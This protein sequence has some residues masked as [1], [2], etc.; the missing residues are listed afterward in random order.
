MRDRW[1]EKWRKERYPRSNVFH[2]IDRIEK[3]MEEMIDEMMR[4]AFSSFEA[5]MKNKRIK[6]PVYVFSITRSPEGRPRIREFDNI[7][8]GRYDPRIM[9]EREPLVDVLGEAE[10]V[11]VVAELQGVEK[12]DIKLHASKG[13]ITISVNTPQRKYHKE[14]LLPEEVDPKPVKTSFKNGVLEVRLKKKGKGKNIHI[15]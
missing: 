9:G 7:Q 8:R 3:M 15:R 14:L 1:W 4:Q 6:S 5:T 11:V 12:D 10:E 13:G 2:E